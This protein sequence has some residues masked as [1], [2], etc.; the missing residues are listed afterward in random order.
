VFN[1]EV[2][3]IYYWLIDWYLTFCQTGP[4]KVQNSVTKS[5]S[6]EALDVCI[7][8]KSSS[9]PT[10]EFKPIAIQTLGSQE[11]ESTRPILRE[12]KDVLLSGFEKYGGHVCAGGDLPKSAG[13][14]AYLSNSQKQHGVSVNREVQ[15][16]IIDP[17]ML[18]TYYGKISLVLFNRLWDIKI[19]IRSTL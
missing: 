2:S 4:D 10:L 3:N 5:L 18:P 17:T 6:A 7:N 14:H 11:K 8:I 16:N 9:A 19:R 15:N 1:Y 13:N 12:Q